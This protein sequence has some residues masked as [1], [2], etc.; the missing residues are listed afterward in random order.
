[1]L[2]KIAW[3]GEKPPY[4][5]WPE[6]KCFVWVL[7]ETHRKERKAHGK[8]EL[9]FYP[10]RWKAKFFLCRGISHSPLFSFLHRVPHP[11]WPSVI[12]SCRSLPPRPPVPSVYPP[13]IQLL[14]LALFL[15]HTKHFSFSFRC[16]RGLWGCLGPSSQVRKSSCDSSSYKSSKPITG[17]RPHLTLT[18]TQRPHFRI[19]SQHLL[20]LR[21]SRKSVQCPSPSGSEAQASWLPG[22]AVTTSNSSVTW[23]GMDG[24]W[25]LSPCLKAAMQL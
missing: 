9:S 3:C 2:Q 18:T 21:P 25:A 13:S 20:R 7:K 8:E 14:G 6:V 24:S 4:I 17:S 19:P 1:M 11:V 12:D 15:Y 10:H 22:V 16:A 23:V 5:W